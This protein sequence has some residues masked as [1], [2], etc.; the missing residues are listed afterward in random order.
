MGF[1]PLLE[2][3]EDSLPVLSAPC[4]LRMQQEGGQGEEH[5]DLGLPNLQDCEK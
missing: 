5:L 2:E 4:Y 3:T 1:V